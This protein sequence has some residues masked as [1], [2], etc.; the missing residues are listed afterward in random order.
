MATLFPGNKSS[1]MNF[2]KKLGNKAR[3]LLSTQSVVP[4]NRSKLKI[5]IE[6]N[7]ENKSCSN[8]LVEPKTFFELYLNLKNSLSK[9][10]HSKTAPKLGKIKGKGT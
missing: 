5:S 4:K 10:K 7:I 2:E 8:I 9:P 3:N 6:G 1:H